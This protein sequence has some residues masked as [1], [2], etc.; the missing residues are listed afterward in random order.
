MDAYPVERSIQSTFNLAE[1]SPFAMVRAYSRI[2]HIRPK[3]L[4]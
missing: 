3:N 2:N 1:K 4:R